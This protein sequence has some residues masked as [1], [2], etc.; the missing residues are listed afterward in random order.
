MLDIADDEKL[1]PKQ[2]SDIANAVGVD[3]A[4]LSY[5]RAA[6]MNADDRLE[7]LLTLS[8]QDYEN[9]DEFVQDLILGK[10][11]VGGKSLF[12]STMFER[13]YDEGLLSKEE[14]TLIGAVKYDAVFN[15]FYM[16]RDFKGGSGGDGTATAA[17]IRSY[18]SSINALHKSPFKSSKI[19][20]NDSIQKALA[21]PLE[22]PKIDFT[23]APKNMG[24]STQH[25]FTQY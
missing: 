7:G 14:K 11:A 8:T 13:L 19:N 10:R 25:W 12:S 1:S 21:E 17:K 2:K 15:K 9:R 20:M 6:S 4:D 23:R 3:G 18:I 16:D 22:A 5:Y 24:T